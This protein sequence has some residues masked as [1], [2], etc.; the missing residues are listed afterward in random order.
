MME[1]T[2]S[3]EDQHNSTIRTD[4]G[5]IYISW[6]PAKVPIQISSVEFQPNL[7]EQALRLPEGLKVGDSLADFIKANGAEIDFYGFGWQ[8]GGMV[9]SKKGKI[10]EAYPCLTLA[11]GTADG[12]YADV[13]DFMGDGTIRSD[14][15]GLPV[16]RIVIT[17]ISFQNEA[18]AL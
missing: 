16:E 8:F 9:I 7:P 5:T 3:T 14:A 18:G 2:V 15:P 11:L 17:A 6:K 12:T 4:K 1:G 13:S 10:L